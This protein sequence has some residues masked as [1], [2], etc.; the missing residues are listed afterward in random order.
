WRQQ[1]RLQKALELL[2]EGR[3]VTSVAIDLGYE[4]PSAFIAMFRRTLGAP[5]TQYLPQS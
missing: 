2:A 3:P 5:P 4:S 1:L